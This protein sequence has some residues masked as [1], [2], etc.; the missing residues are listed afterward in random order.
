MDQQTATIDK[1]SYQ[2]EV[3][4]PVCLP[5]NDIAHGIVASLVKQIDFTTESQIAAIRSGLSL[6]AY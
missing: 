6:P 1:L 3:T 5:Y 2:I 4:R